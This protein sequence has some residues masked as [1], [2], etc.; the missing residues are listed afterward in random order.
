MKLIGLMNVIE[1]WFLAIHQNKIFYSTEYA[2]D[3]L[4]ILKSS[5]ISRILNISISPN[6][7]KFL[8]IYYEKFF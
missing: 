2:S 6:K 4:L 7:I 1:Q 8:K 3:I 5:S